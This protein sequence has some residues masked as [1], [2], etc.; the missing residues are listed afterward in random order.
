MRD[1]PDQLGL[2]VEKNKLLVS[3]DVIEC[4]SAHGTTMAD[5]LVAQIDGGQRIGKPRSNQTFEFHF[6]VASI[7]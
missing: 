6:Y 2:T 4:D 3:L 1:T 5:I 7:S